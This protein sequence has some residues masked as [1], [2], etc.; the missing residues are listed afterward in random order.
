M[1]SSSRAA[2]L[3]ILSVVLGTAFLL[4]GRS[5]R[6]RAESNHRIAVPFTLQT[7]T[8]SFPNG[9]QGDLMSKDLT[10]RRSDGT[11]VVVST[12]LPRKPHPRMLRDIR[13][14]D[15]RVV[16]LVD[17]VAAKTEFVRQEEAARRNQLLL[18]PPPGCVLVGWEKPSGT[19]TVLGHTVDVVTSFGHMVWRARDLGCET[20]QSREGY[21]H[22]DGFLLEGETTAVS[23]KLGEPDPRLFDEGVNYAEVKPSELLRRQMAHVGV[24][25]NDDLEREAVHLDQFYSPKP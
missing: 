12:L 7:E 20:V 14:P 8:F 22:G 10:A 21:K 4:I 17:P 13:Y 1:A 23:L 19:D 2:T 25:W 18:S 15:G 3:A 16:R 6:A 24:T 11:T 9:A 5:R